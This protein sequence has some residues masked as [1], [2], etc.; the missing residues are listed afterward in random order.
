MDRVAVVSSN[1]ASVGFDSATQTL[2]VEFHS[3][4]I[5]DY[6]QVSGFIYQGLMD[7]A[8]KDHYLWAVIKK[9]GYAYKKV[10]DYKSQ[11]GEPEGTTITPIEETV[12]ALGLGGLLVPPATA[13]TP[14]GSLP[15]S[16]L[17]SIPT[18]SP[19]LEAGI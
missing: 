18:V 7:A 4:D 8:S 16:V 14:D 15:F 2:E 17:P 3:G 13:T 1:L 10:F 6:S 12:G 9:G 19:A 5:Y 11:I